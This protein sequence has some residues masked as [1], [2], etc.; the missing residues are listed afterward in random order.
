MFDGGR[1]MATV[2]LSVMLFGVTAV[3]V[4]VPRLPVGVSVPELEI[5]ANV[6]SDTV[7][8]IG[9]PDTGALL[10]SKPATVKATGVGETTE[11]VLG[12]TTMR[13]TVAPGPV[14]WT[15]ICCGGA[16]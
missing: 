11:V 16:G 4:T 14:Y 3:T 2:A 13:A 9:V 15:V 1:R 10:A 6:G 8:L 12:D 5:A 7:Q